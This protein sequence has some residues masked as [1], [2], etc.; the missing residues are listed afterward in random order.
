MR[1]S[2]GVME[3]CK[4]S[5]SKHQITGFRFQFFCLLFL[6]PDTRHLETWCLEFD[7]LQCSIT[8]PLHYSRRLSHQGKTIRAS[9]VGISKLG[10]PGLDSFTSYACKW[11]VKKGGKKGRQKRDG[12]WKRNGK[13]ASHYRLA[14]QISWSGRLDLNPENGDENQW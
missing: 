12:I 1:E 3:H 6:T 7:S 2:P 4:L 13:R 11:K 9:S 8:P 5:N 14:L 10:P